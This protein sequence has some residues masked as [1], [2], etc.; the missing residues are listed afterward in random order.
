MRRYEQEI[1]HAWDEDVDV[2]CYL[3]ELEAGR[4]N[5]TLIV[6]HPWTLQGVIVGDKSDAG[7]TPFLNT[8]ALDRDLEGA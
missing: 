6:S 3:P 1:A 4:Y 7:S 2:T 5:Y 8:A